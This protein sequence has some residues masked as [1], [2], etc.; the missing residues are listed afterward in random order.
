[1]VWGV[2]LLF[3]ETLW[4][5][6]G[7][8]NLNVG[9]L[10]QSISNIQ[11]HGRRANSLSRSRGRCGA[12]ENLTRRTEWTELRQRLLSQK[13][14]A[15]SVHSLLLSITLPPRL[16][17]TVPQAVVTCY[18]FSYLYFSLPR[19]RIWMP[20]VREKQIISQIVVVVT[21]QLRLQQNIKKDNQ[22][23]HTGIH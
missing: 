5:K 15:C 14:T 10:K 7:L 12:I 16:C 23:N 21:M 18:L 1:M 2:P 22:E 19:N 3:E 8:S 13:K 11:G 17:L 9:W 4:A 6:Q 20:G